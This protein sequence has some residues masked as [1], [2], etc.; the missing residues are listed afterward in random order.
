[1]SKI[2]I[3]EPACSF[4]DCRYNSDCNCIAGDN[5]RQVCEFK[6]YHDAECDNRLFIVPPPITTSDIEA[7]KD[8]GRIVRNL[9]TMDNLIN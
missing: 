1:M 6:K 5:R 8:I 4:R 7:I 3:D 2:R 9:D